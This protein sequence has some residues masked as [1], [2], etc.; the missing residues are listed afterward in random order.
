MMYVMTVKYHVIQINIK[1]QFLTLCEII[2]E[3]NLI[4]ILMKTL[5]GKCI[6]LYYSILKGSSRG[7]VVTVLDSG[8]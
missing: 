6:I 2:L 8:L 4:Y 7:L 5:T 1:H 3:I